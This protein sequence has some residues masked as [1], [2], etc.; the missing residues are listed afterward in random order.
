MGVDGSVPLQPYEIA[1]LRGGPRAAVTVAVVDLHLRGVVEA[2]RPGRL[3]TSGASE[4]APG[5]G[6]PPPRSGES[7][8]APLA[9][10]VRAELVRP[11]G[12]AELMNRPAVRRALADLAAALRSARLLRALP[13]HRSRAGRRALQTLLAGHPLPASGKGVAA[14]EA[15]LAVALH[16][17][18]ALSLLV[19]RFALRAGLV[20][21]TEV[22]DQGFHRNAPRGGGTGGYFHCGGAASCGGSY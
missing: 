18:A 14:D 9:E 4:D 11:A 2:G 20:P 10:A 17:E 6:G 22:T 16:G 21:G 15:V 5:Q 12:P 8:L 19:P 1:L 3:R 7:A 13:P